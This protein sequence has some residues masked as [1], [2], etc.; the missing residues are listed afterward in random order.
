MKKH[1]INSSP[2]SIALTLT[3]LSALTL[4]QGCQGGGDDEVQPSK[5][6]KIVDETS[7]EKDKLT[8]NGNGRITSDECSLI[9]FHNKMRVKGVTNSNTDFDES[10]KILSATME[11]SIYNRNKE[12]IPN[13]SLDAQMEE[14]EYDQYAQVPVRFPRDMIMWEA[15]FA[16]F[17]FSIS[18][19]KVSYPTAGTVS[20]T[21]KLDLDGFNDCYNVYIVTLFN[22]KYTGSL[23]DRESNKRVIE[24]EDSNIEIF[25]LGEGSASMGK[26][27]VVKYD[28]LSYLGKKNGFDGRKEYNELIK[29]SEM[30]PADQLKLQQMMQGYGEF[31]SDLRQ[32]MNQLSEDLSVN[33]GVSQSAAL[34]R[35]FIGTPP[36][37]VG[38]LMSMS[39]FESKLEALR[40]KTEK[41]I[42]KKEVIYRH[43]WR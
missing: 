6:I 27:A 22:D 21:Q 26:M 13:S 34:T 15:G 11:K 30:S 2:K 41:K 1:K 3:A 39:A 12:L 24:N 9:Y 18:N 37:L 32:R 36:E 7:V 8:E 23:D 20:S 14:I 29:R 19:F 43:R 31:M 16:S 5:L 42:E 17:K 10:G 40:K 35:A 38:K 33:S 4:I 28:V 25:S